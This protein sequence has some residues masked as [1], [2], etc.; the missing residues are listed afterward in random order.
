MEGMLAPAPENRPSA[1]H[2]EGLLSAAPFAEPWEREE[3]TAEAS[4]PTLALGAAVAGDGQGTGAGASGGPEETAALG[5]DGGYRH[6]GGAGPAR[7]LSTTEGQPGA[8]SAC[9][10]E[11]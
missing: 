9:C 7:P 3:P 5:G 6:F 11:R 8:E 10:G 4:P 1:A 2:V